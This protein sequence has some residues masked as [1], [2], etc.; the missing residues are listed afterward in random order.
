MGWIDRPGNGGN[1]S[2]LVSGKG[3]AA[4]GVE[5]WLMTSFGLAGKD[6]FEAREDGGKVA[7]ARGD[8]VAEDK[9]AEA[10]EEVEVEGVAE[11]R[12]EVEAEEV[13][14]EVAEEEGV[15]AR[16]FAAALRSDSNCSSTRRSR[17]RD[18]LFDL[19]GCCSSDMAWFRDASECQ[20]IRYLFLKNKIN[21]Q[22]NYRHTMMRMRRALVWY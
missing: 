12:E 3:T 10:R 14:E 18:L 21:N 17:L 15:N 2:S 6:L 7:E 13:A 8:D 5:G 9:V 22:G 4:K 1:S 16:F 19:T 11:A 20:T